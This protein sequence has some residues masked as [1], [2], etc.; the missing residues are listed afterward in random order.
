MAS[1]PITSQLERE[2]VETVILGS[3][4]TV[5][6]D[7]HEMKRHL[8]LERKAMTNLDIIFKKAQTSLT[9]RSVLSKLWFSSSHVRMRVGP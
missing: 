9:D 2:K 6:S 7:C 4:I 8:L 1:S 5:E 3:K